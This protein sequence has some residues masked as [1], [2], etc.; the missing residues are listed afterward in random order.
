MERVNTGIAKKLKSPCRTGNQIKSLVP[1]DQEHEH[2][3]ETTNP[4]LNGQV[5]KPQSWDPDLNS[6]SSLG[7]LNPGFWFRCFS[8]KFRTYLNPKELILTWRENNEK[9]QPSIYTDIMKW[10]TEAAVLTIYQKRNRNSQI[11]Y[12]LY[13]STLLNLKRMSLNQQSKVF[14]NLPIWCFLQR[15]G[16]RG[17]KEQLSP[18]DFGLQKKGESPT[19]KKWSVTLT[20]RTKMNPLHCTMVFS[21][22]S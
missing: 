2:H 15:P 20:G 10:K 9:T 12:A 11:P 8:V 4:S 6:T 18:P 19:R 5:S 21:L 22:L 14:H 3:I 13:N 17:K 7:C 16:L 1:K